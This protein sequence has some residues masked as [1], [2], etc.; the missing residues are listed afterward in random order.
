[1]DS[2]QLIQYLTQFTISLLNQIIFITQYVYNEHPTIFSLVSSVIVLYIT[3]RLVIRIAKAFYNAIVNIMT[4]FLLVCCI[5]AIMALWSNLTD[6]FTDG[7]L[8]RFVYDD[9]K[10]QFQPAAAWSY[11]L[12]SLSVGNLVSLISSTK[13]FIDN[14]LRELN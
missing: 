6:Y 7:T 5:V 14:L 11:C 1:M 8:H 13:F 4:L 10:F 12:N 3:I 2:D 9:K